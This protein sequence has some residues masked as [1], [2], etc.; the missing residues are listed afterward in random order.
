MLTSCALAA[1]SSGEGSDKSRR[2]T[3]T[4]AETSSTSTTEP[5]PISYQVQPG[6][7]LTK[8]AAFF[9]VSTQFL[10]Q[11]NNLG[12]GDRL[13][14]GQV[15]TIPPRPT[16]TLTVT[17]RTG[18]PG[19]SF[20]L[21]LVGAET[22]EL[23]RFEI[24]APSGESFTG[25]P[26]VAVEGQSVT[27]SYDSDLDAAPGRYEVAAHGDRGATASASFRLKRAPAP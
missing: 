21:E 24:T 18:E 19:D 17:P 27:A 10:A 12:N 9:G 14:A 3:T 7:T 15:L 16:V 25:P 22:G 11:A 13:T 20:A 4:N 5:G 8:I 26:H 2:S 6:D 1:C 23:V